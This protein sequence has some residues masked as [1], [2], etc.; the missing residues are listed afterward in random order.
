M[1]QGT[2]GGEDVLM[3]DARGTKT[4]RNLTDPT[5][6]AREARR[7]VSLERHYHCDS[8]GSERRSWTRMSACPECG[9]AFVA[10]VIR[11][12]AFA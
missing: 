3:I 12:A 2:L 8:C 9:E 1:G 4:G 5:A 11:R 7:L 10:A 6:V